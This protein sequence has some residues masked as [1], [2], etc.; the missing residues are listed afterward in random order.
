MRQSPS[1]FTTSVLLAALVTGCAGGYDNDT[2]IGC[3][4]DSECDEDEVCFIDGC[5]NP[6]KDI[7]VEV[8]PNPKAGQ[9]AQDFRVDDLRSQQNIELLDP[10]S[11]QGQVLVQG[12]SS[13]SG[14]PASVTLRM[15]GESLLIPGVMRYHESTFVPQNGG[16][17]LPVASGRYSVTLLA[18]NSEQ[19]PLTSTRDVQPGRAVSLDFLLP[20]TSRLV[21]LSGKVVDQK[22]NPMDVDMEVQALDDQ[23]RPLSQRVLATRLAGMFTLALPPAAALRDT[24]ILQVLPTSAASLVPQK[25]FTVSP[26]PD[27]QQTLSMGDYGEPVRFQGRV[28]DRAG[29][30]VPQATVYLAGGVGG[31]GQYRSQTVLT[32]DKGDFELLTLPSGSSSSMTLSVIPPS[33]SSAGYTQR[34]VS[35]PR[36]SVTQTPDVVCQERM[37]VRGSLLKP[38]DSRP[39]AGVRV[40]A[41]PIEALPGWPRPAVSVEAPRPT[42]ENG[43][44]ELALDPGRYRFDFIPTEDLPIVSRIVLV[45]PEEDALSTGTLEL[46]PFTL[47]KGRR[48]TGRISFNGERLARSSAPYASIRFFRVVEVEGKPSPLLLAQ[49]LTD[50][51]G[52]YSTTLPAR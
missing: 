14:Y 35:V 47:S 41:E 26:R 30:P 3:R 11:L 5:G 10:A 7:V 46:T 39:A 45:R 4:S 24:V 29:Q 51:N 32:D 44:F 16:Y 52:N 1:R 50:Q 18:T 22:G 34:Y 21:R 48:V 9:H 6:G 13:T 8:V 36:V 20:D 25:L 28:L 49:T 43:N 42:D 33:G 37:K 12:T 19:P 40:V 38:S 23:L 2:F 15:T 27:L 31:G 17:S